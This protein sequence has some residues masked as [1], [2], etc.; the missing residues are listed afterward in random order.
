MGGRG[1]G[2]SEYEASLV[3]RA[4]SRAAQATQINPVLKTKQNKTKQN[5]NPTFPLKKI[6]LNDKMSLLIKNIKEMTDSCGF[7]RNKE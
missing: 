1:R 2:I 3:Y 7:T 6:H 4:R 5:K